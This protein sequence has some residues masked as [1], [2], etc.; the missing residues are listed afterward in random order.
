MNRT[1][2]YPS[3]SMRSSSPQLGTPS[4]GHP[5]VTKAVE[6]RRY[7]LVDIDFDPAESD[8]QLLTPQLPSR[9]KL[10][11]EVGFS[12]ENE[13][14]ETSVNGVGDVL[15]SSNPCQVSPRDVSAAVCDELRQQ[16][17]PFYAVDV[18]S[19]RDCCS[20]TREKGDKLIQRGISDHVI[21]RAVSAGPSVR[22]YA[23]LWDDSPSPMV[24]LRGSRSD[25]GHN[26]RM[27]TRDV[28]KPLAAVH[29]SSVSK[30][31]VHE[32]MFSQRT[33][34][35]CGSDV[36][37]PSRVLHDSRD[38]NCTRGSSCLC[39]KLMQK[40]SS[41]EPLSQVRQQPR[42]V[43][44]G[45]NCGQKDCENIALCHSDAVTT[46]DLWK[47]GVLSD[48]IVTH[49]A[50][51]FP[52]IE[53]ETAAKN[54]FEKFSSEF[55]RLGYQ[56][57]PG[58]FQF[59]QQFAVEK[60]VQPTNNGGKVTVVSELQS[61]NKKAETKTNVI[62]FANHKFPRS[63]IA[64]TKDFTVN[65]RSLSESAD[66]DLREQHFSQMASVVHPQSSHFEDNGAMV[67]RSSA[68]N[69]RFPRKD[70]MKP[71]SF[72]GKEPV[73]SFLAHFEVCAKL[74]GW[75]EEQKY[76]GYSGH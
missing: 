20:E 49:S 75:S 58:T 22:R 68:E 45:L 8:Q 24:L 12:I 33:I 57:E 37:L 36:N 71:Q 23:A 35:E 17:D 67:T 32:G 46:T 18:N 1:Q 52:E 9:D 27:N 59:N 11:S 62:P 55:K 26:G 54:L 10:V 5:D 21:D 72:D 41:R 70:V 50:P 51:H 63:L 53:R 43:D 40:P 61:S 60:Q 2:P 76:H 65:D 28:N 7:H 16:F 73:N 31:P 56:F 6:A 69:E 38:S 29:D 13:G 74:N 39:S 15:N 14:V 44:C 30:E 66:I 64:S 3:E 47:K 25:P 34:V 4:C 19:T 48:N 42:Q